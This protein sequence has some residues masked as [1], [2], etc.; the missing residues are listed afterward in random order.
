MSL[1]NPLA[2]RDGVVFEQKCALLDTKMIIDERGI[3]IVI[4]LIDETNITRDKYNSIKQRGTSTLTINAYPL[5][6]SPTDEDKSDAGLREDT[7]VI[8]HTAMLDWTNAG[9]D[10]DTIDLIRA[11]VFISGDIY[12]VRDKAKISQFGT[13]YLYVVLGLNKK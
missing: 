1:G 12:E 5:I 10:I 9:F 7:D 2:C 11:E 4:N 3:S 8:A 6:F 13:S